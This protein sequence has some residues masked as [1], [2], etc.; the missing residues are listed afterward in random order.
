MGNIVY[1]HYVANQ[2]PDWL[3]WVKNIHLRSHLELFEKFIELNP[4]FVPANHQGEAEIKLVEKL[5]WNPEYINSLSDKG[6]QVWVAAGFLDFVDELR[7][8][9][10]RF[11]EVSKICDFLEGNQAWFERTYAFL[12]ADIIEF[13]RNNGRNI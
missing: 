9:G 10:E 4:H 7:V 1:R 11:V 13:L 3:E 6:I 12:R 5:M 8:Y 2:M